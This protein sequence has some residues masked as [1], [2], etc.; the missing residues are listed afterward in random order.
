MASNQPAQQVNPTAKFNTSAGSVS[1]A[2]FFS[3]ALND[4]ARASAYI[5]P[6]SSGGS[7]SAVPYAA[8]AG[9]MAAAQNSARSA[10]ARFKAS[11]DDGLDGSIN[12][13]GFE[14]MPAVQVGV[15]A[16]GPLIN[17]VHA[18]AKLHRLDFSL[19]TNSSTAELKEIELSDVVA[20][21]REVLQRTVRHWISNVLP[22]L[23]A[24]SRAEAEKIHQANTEPLQIVD[25][26]LK[27]SS[28]VAIPGLVEA[29]NAVRM[30]KFHFINMLLAGLN[31]SEGEFWPGFLDLAQTLGLLYAPEFGSADKNGKFV[32]VEAALDQAEDRSDVDGLQFQSQLGLPEVPVGRVLIPRIPGASLGRGEE[33]KNTLPSQATRTSIVYPAGDP[34]GRTALLSPPPFISP[35]YQSMAGLWSA[36]SGALGASSIRENMSRQQKIAS[37]QQRAIHDFLRG[38]AELMFKR[39]KLQ[40][41]SAAFSMPLS[42]GWNV[43]TAYKV[44]VGGT[45]LFTGLLESVNHSIGS[46]GG[47][48]TASTELAFSNVLWG[49]NT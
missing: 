5:H 31:S 9:I 3:A 28:P 38:Y 2:G 14:V 18:T 36:P 30:V 19:Y 39:M 10:T 7:V 41:S 35:V 22:D 29:A 32:S 17:A 43:G 40:S 6:S 44:G 4:M 8:I 45:P 37:T 11:S 33:R 48:G 16:V 23:P 13:E 15:A 26:I 47:T 12:F 1:D 46:R 49:S 25:R 27:A 42:Y 20:A 24:G 34:V 21:L